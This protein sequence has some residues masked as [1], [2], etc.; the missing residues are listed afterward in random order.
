MLVERAT[1]SPDSPLATTLRENRSYA[2]KSLMRSHSPVFAVTHLTPT[3]TVL[4]TLFSLCWRFVAL[5]PTSFKLNGISR[6][7]R[8]TLDP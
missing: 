8:P 2:P 5:L 6:R 4:P 3:G 1:P 7:A